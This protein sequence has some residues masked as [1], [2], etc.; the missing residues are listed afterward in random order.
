MSDP[1]RTCVG[2]G[3][4]LPAKALVRLVLAGGRVA[5]GTPGRG[6][7]GAWL[8]AEASCVERAAKRRALARALRSA[9]AAAG[10]AALRSLVDGK[11]P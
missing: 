10:A 4:R 11:C 3:A 7:R 1:V 5:R 2:C 9:E 8:H 6:G